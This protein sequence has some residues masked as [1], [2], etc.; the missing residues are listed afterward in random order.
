MGL[1]TDIGDE[2]RTTGA[3]CA[4][5]IT[6]RIVPYGTDNLPA[7]ERTEKGARE[8]ITGW[9][10]DKTPFASVEQ[11]IVYA[12]ADACRRIIASQGVKL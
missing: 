5:G 4:A 11:A 10:E 7:V 6:Y 3:T 2:L 12:A 8:V 9:D 1:L